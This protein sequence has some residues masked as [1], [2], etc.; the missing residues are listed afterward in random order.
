MLYL[1][2]VY[3]KSVALKIQ[4]VLFS[5]VHAASLAA[6]ASSLACVAFYSAAWSDASVKEIVCKKILPVEVWE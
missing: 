4:S 5:R 6:D 1:I 3:S 2:S